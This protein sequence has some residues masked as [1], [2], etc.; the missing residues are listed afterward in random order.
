MEYKENFL[1]KFLFH[2]TDDRSGSKLLRL[3][4]SKNPAW[5]LLQKLG[6]GKVPIRDNPT[7]TP[8]AVA[9]HI[10]STS[11]A[12]RD[13][14]HTTQ[15]RREF[16]RL[17]ATT[18]LQSEF[19]RLFTHVDIT[20][21]LEDVKPGKAPGLDKIHP[22]FLINLGKSAREWLANLSTNILN[23][24][25]IPRQ[26]KQ[27]KMIAILKPGKPNDKPESFRPIAPFF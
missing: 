10:V 27:M 6:S 15:V 18:D 12:P 16:K 23:T 11:E 13:R 22:E 20:K 19:Y 4:I 14:E 17:K 5:S 2:S 8:S 26:L 25:S 1:V 9:P 3:W 7:V 24:G 21:A